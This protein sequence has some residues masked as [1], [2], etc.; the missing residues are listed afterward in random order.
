MPLIDSS[1]FVLLFWAVA[2]YLIGSV[3]FGMVL[4]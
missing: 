1:L 2:A 4:T 3:P